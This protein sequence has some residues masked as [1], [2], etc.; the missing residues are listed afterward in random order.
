MLLKKLKISF[1][2]RIE[3]ILT[4]SLKWMQA[5]PIYSHYLFTTFFYCNKT[6]PYLISLISYQQNNQCSR[7]F[8]LMTTIIVL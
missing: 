7:K 2:C 4:Y 3:I 5:I 1:K 6:M 8:M